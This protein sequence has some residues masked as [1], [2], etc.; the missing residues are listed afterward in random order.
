MTR[1]SVRS[2]K[3]GGTGGPIGMLRV[4]DPV[5]AL[6]HRCAVL[7]SVEQASEALAEFIA[8]G[9]EQQERVIIAGLP[10]HQVRTCCSGSAK[11]TAS[12]PT[13]RSPMVNSS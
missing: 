2:L 12:T 8:D 7:G 4:V 6:P 10:D 1:G 11:R 3:G 13:R 5:R 9:I